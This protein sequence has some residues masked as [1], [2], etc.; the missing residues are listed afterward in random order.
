[1][2]NFHRGDSGGGFAPGDRPLDGRGAAIFRQERGVQVDIAE[3]G[4]I[5]HPLRNDA[6]VTDDDDGVRL[7]LGE[8][9]AE[10]GVV[11]DAFG[12]GDR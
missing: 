8:L 11:L 4:Q 1:M 7:E 10:A 2:V 3:R 9:S 12:L 6:A 5:E